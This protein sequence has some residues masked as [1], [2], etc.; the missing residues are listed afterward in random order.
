MI[1]DLRDE[2]DR[3]AEFDDAWEGEPDDFGLDPSDD[4]S[5]RT[6]ISAA[7]LRRQVQDDESIEQT[8]PI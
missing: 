6:T 1:T 7:R 2:R 5:D 8:L 4:V 3:E